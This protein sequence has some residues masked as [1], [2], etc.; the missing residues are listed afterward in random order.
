M[1]SGAEPGRE[2]GDPAPVQVQGQVLSRGRRGGDHSGYHPQALLPSGYGTRILV[3]K[4][5]K[6]VNKTKNISNHITEDS[7]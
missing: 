2:E 3:I 1:L 5:L 6:Q 4:Q 7:F